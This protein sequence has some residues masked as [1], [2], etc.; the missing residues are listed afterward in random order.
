M[1]GFNPLPG[2][3]PLS[4]RL[5]PNW[6]IGIGIVLITLGAVALVDAIV[7]TL[8][9]VV[10]LGMLLIFSGIAYLGQSFA[11]R[12]VPGSRFWITALMGFLY[13]LSG[14]LLI[15]EPITGSFFLTA[16]MAG[17]LMASGVMRGIWAAGNRHVANWW[18]LVLSAVVSLLTGIFIFVTLPWSGLWLIGT[19]IGIELIFGGVSAIAFGNALK[20][21]GR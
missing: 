16:F 3:P 2:M 6:F 14:I 11:H 9:S 7:A 15:Q 21:D 18:M 12:D 10:V 8:A 20:R 5:K 17:C 13:A 19:F 1:S 4:P